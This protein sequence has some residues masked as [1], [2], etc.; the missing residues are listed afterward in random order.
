MLLSLGGVCS[1]W[2]DIGA[3]ALV[4]LVVVGIVVLDRERFLACGFVEA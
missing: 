3:D 2:L 1:V 4:I